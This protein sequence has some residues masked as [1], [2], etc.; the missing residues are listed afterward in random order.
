MF[1][2]PCGVPILYYCLLSVV[3]HHHRLAENHRRY[4]LAFLET[5]SLR[6]RVL[7]ELCS[8]RRPG[9]NICVPPHSWPPLTASSPWH[10]F[11]A[12]A[13]ASC[14][15]S[16][17]FV[18]IMGTL[19]I[20]LRDNPGKSPLCEVVNNS[21]KTFFQIREYSQVLEIRAWTYLSG[22]SD[23]VAYSAVV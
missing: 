4:L 21:T 19:V 8:L 10:P 22:G 9:A 14:S 15:V 18:S 16:F 17:I 20:A 7:E 23:S 2:G 3:T 12:A 1:L 13:M 11:T 6:S 5:R